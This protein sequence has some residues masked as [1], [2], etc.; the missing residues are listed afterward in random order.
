M[1]K[2]DLAMMSWSEVQ[3]MATLLAT[4]SKIKQLSGKIEIK[5]LC[6]FCKFSIQKLLFYQQIIKFARIYINSK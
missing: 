5:C 6:F 1:C 3:K 4:K 2:N